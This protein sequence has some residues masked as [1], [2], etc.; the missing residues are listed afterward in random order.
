MKWS[1]DIWS[2]I[3]FKPAEDQ[4]WTIKIIHDLWMIWKCRYCLVM[5]FNLMPECPM[6]NKPRSSWCYLQCMRF[7]GFKGRPCVGLWIFFR[8]LPSSLVSSWFWWS[9][10][11]QHSGWNWEFLLVRALHSSSVQSS[12]QPKVFIPQFQG[13]ANNKSRYLINNN[14]PLCMAGCIGGSIVVK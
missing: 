5:I 7:S 10:G 13:L 2:V 11:V 3:I 9:S 6:W 1:R 14:R 8:A 12:A 4:K